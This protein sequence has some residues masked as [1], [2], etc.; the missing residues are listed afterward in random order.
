MTEFSVDDWIEA[1]SLGEGQLEKDQAI[2]TDYAGCKDSLW[3]V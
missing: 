3:P 2:V 1:P